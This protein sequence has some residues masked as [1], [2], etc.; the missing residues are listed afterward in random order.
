MAVRAIDRRSPSG[1]VVCIEVD[2]E[3]SFLRQP[4]TFLLG[5]LVDGVHRP[6]RY[7]RDVLLRV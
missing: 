6:K 1:P 5:P 2:L 7:Y 4:E 3:L